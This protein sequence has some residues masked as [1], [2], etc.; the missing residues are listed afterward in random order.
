MNLRGLVNGAVQVVHPNSLLTVRLSTGAVD[1]D[2][3][4]PQP[5]YATP[6]LFTGSIGGTV[7]TVSNLTQGQLQVGQQIAGAGIVPGTRIVF[8]DSA[9]GTFLVEPA[10]T[11]APTAVTA[12][13][14]VAGN[15]QPLNWRDLQQLDAINLGGTRNKIYL[16]GSI[17]AIVRSAGNGGD[18]I[19]DPLG[20]VYLVATVAEQWPGWCAVFATLQ[21][22][23][24]P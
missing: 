14:I 23:V 9:L 4:V 19:I 1:D 17:N 24:S 8:A 2:A 10:Q 15:V 6:A 5:T 22:E 18:L 13:R 11:V 16:F 7:L 20:N 3:G 12:E 21:N